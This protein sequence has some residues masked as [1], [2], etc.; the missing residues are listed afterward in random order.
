MRG[1]SPPVTA[2]GR[3][4]KTPTE[5]GA[6]AVARIAQQLGVKP[7]DDDDYDAT[8]RTWK[9]HRAEIR[10]LLG[11]REAT[12]ADAEQLES[13]LRDQVAAV[14]AAPDQLLALLGARC[15][16]LSIEPP[17]AD[18]IDRIVR[19]AIH[20]HDERFCAG[21]LSR[22]APA[23]RARLEALLRPAANESSDPPSEQSSAPAL[24]L[25]LRGDPGKPSL[26]GV[27]DEL[28]KLELVRG[29]DLPPALFDG[30]LPHELERY[31]RRVAAEAPYELRRHPEAARLT[32]LAAFVHLRGRTLTDDLVDLLIETIH[33]IGARAERRVEREL[34]DELKHVS[35]KQN[36]LFD[37]AGATLEQPDG[38]VRDVIFPVVG[39][40]TLRDLVKEA[41][42]TGPSYRTTLRTVIRNSYKGHYRRMVPEILQRLEFCS[43]NERH[44]PIIQALDLLKRYADSKLQTFPQGWHPNP[45]PANAWQAQPASTRFPHQ[46]RQCLPRPPQGMATPLPWRGDEEPAQLPW[47]AP[48][49]GGAGEKGHARGFYLRSY[50]FRPISTITA[51]RAKFFGSDFNSLDSPDQASARRS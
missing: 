45:H 51:I 15:R 38:I 33:R 17:A 37:L 44:R 36:L 18:R 50:R 41:K 48:H 24:L 30:V 19:A 34:L 25:R 9:R 23:T 14:G 8:S 40:Q 29:I 43:N 4:P 22:L 35:G 49:S 2:H 12:V 5:I 6:K 1:S 3:F 31:R 27:Q 10:V 13:W 32:W 39:E 47:L 28:A 16:E 7:S 11:F 26:A 42:A 46:Q 21:V 20:A